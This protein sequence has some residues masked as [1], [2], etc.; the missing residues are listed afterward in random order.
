[1]SRRRSHPPISLFSFQ[2]IIM[3]VVGVV[4]LITLILLLHFVSQMLAAPPEPTITEEELRQ[5]IASL[6][7]I[8]AK[9]RDSV[10]YLQQL[11]EESEVFT[12][13]QDEVDALQSAV[14]QL[15]TD[16][17]LTEKTIEEIKKRIDEL[18][19]D[20][21]KQQ[22]F[23][24]QQEV[25]R[26]TDLIAGLRPRA[27]QSGVQMRVVTPKNTDKEAFIVDY[28][29]GIITVIP[30]DGSSKRTFASA[31]QF[32]NWVSG[33]DPKKEHYVVYV[34][35]SRFREH[36]ASG[37]HNPIVTNLREKGFDVGFQVIGERTY[38]TLND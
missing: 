7:P 5:Q 21:A 11:R 29:S 12:P 17:A 9:L 16:I 37:R 18:Q 14:T 28:G 23:E 24:T 15:E 13:S 20:P 38:L 35:P 22:L 34:R 32:N 2:D 8:Q 31:A 26:L 1:M 3:S 33:R 27:G 30:A 19:N 25:K 4:I 36:N 10:S 6:K